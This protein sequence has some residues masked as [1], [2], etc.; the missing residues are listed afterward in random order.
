[1]GFTFSNFFNNV[2]ANS[3]FYCFLK[4]GNVS[5]NFESCM[6]SRNKPFSASLAST[7]YFLVTSENSTVS[8]KNSNFIDYYAAAIYMEISS[9]V[10]VNLANV[11]FTGT[12]PKLSL[13]HAI[14]INTEKYCILNFKGLVVTD[15]FS[16]ATNG[17]LYIYGGY[18]PYGY[19]LKLTDSTF[20]NNYCSHGSIIYINFKSDQR[21]SQFSN[22]TVISNCMFRNNMVEDPHAI[23]YVDNEGEIWFV[24]IESSIFIN[25]IGSALYISKCGLELKGDMLFQSNTANS[26]AAI[27]CTTGSLTRWNNGSIDFVDNYAKL[28]GGAIYVSITQ[29]CYNG[30]FFVGVNNVSVN[31]SGNSAEISGNSMYFS[32]SKECNYNTNISDNYSLLYYPSKF[33]YSGHFDEEVTTS[34]FK[35][36]LSSPAVCIDAN[37]TNSYSACSI[38][39]IMLGQE[40]VLPVKILDYIGSLTEPLLFLVTCVNNCEHYRFSGSNPIFVNNHLQGISV[41][42]KEVVYDVPSVT[43]LLSSVKN[44]ND[45]SKEICINFTVNLTKCFPGFIY[46]QASKICVCYNNGILT[47]SG[48]N[49]KIKHGY[50]FGIWKGQA[51]TVFCPLGYCS[52]SKCD[53]SEYCALSHVQD[54]QCHHHRAGPSCS[55]CDSDHILSF[56]SNHC[57]KKSSCFTGVTVVILISCFLYCGLLIGIIIVLKNFDFEIGIG[58]AYGILYFYSIID[59]LLEDQLSVSDDAVYKFVAILSGFAKLTPQFLATLCFVDSTEWSGID[60]Q[61][62]HY[63]HPVGV[64]L[65]LILIVFAA[66]YSTTVTMLIRKSILRAICLLLLITYTSITSTSVELLRPLK[67]QGISETFTYSSPDKLYFHGRHIFYGIIAIICTIVIVIGFPLLLILEPFISHKVDFSRIRPLLDHYQGCFKDK[68][69]V[70]AAFYL[71]CRLAIITVVYAEHNNYYNRLFTLNVMCI[72]I[73]MIHASV[74]PYK[75]NNLNALDEIILLAI[76]FVV[77]FSNGFSYTT[78]NDANSEL[79]IAIVIFPLIV[80]AVYIIKSLKCNIF[81]NRFNEQSNVLDYDSLTENNSNENDINDINRPRHMLR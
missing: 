34:P 12:K 42:G 23:A 18:S 35:L 69:R 61:F 37:D 29:P 14:Y 68:Y 81:C 17:I 3:T 27:F 4:E 30:E 72:V 80:F 11:T 73:A 39:G 5:I 9:L 55:N 2:G 21:N 65:I 40:I 32:L 63:V 20:A 33:N 56:D 45:A 43:L 59:I 70:F 77:N 41:K 67:F 26:G 16:N 60:Q 36:N 48:K 76:I 74:M 54:E 52:F 46:D 28:R 24:S 57:V 78:F 31:F 62:F 51:T 7:I 71:L 44:S 53:D 22:T 8:I 49:A 6:F 15:Y 64:T 79:T 47:C 1:M 10:H 38:S 66:R 58:Y 19:Y 13:Q 50:W 25:N 75:N